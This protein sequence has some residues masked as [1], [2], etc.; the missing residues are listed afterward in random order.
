MESQ[1]RFNRVPE[2]A[3][4]KVSGHGTPELF[5]AEDPIGYYAVGEKK[6]GATAQQL[7]GVRRA[8]TNFFSTLTPGSHG[9]FQVG[10][11][12]AREQLC[13]IIV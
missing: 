11:F 6:T 3:P 13:K 12:W 2:K 8:K 1:V 9:G 7:R 4:E 5:W 10:K